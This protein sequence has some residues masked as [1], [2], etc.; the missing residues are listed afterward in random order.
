MAKRGGTGKT[1][2]LEGKDTDSGIL[3]LWLQVTGGNSFAEPDHVISLSHSPRKKE[4]SPPFLF[5]VSH[6][7]SPSIF[8]LFTFPDAW[9]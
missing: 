3:K 7:K 4:K 6:R 5:V 9:N 8:P 2:S 1:K